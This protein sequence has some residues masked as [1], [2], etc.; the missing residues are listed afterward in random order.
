MKMECPH[1]CGARFSVM[2]NT[3]PRCRKPAGATDYLVQK[4]KG[5]WHRLWGGKNNVFKADCP[6][7]KTPFSLT[8]DT[9]PTCGT[10]VSAASLIAAYA[11][12]LVAALI[13][14]RG[15]ANRASPFEA[16]AIRFGCFLASAAT[17]C[18]LLA[19]AERKFVNGTNDWISPALATCIYVGLSLS[20]LTWF[21]PKNLGPL[22]AQLKLLIKLS[23]LSNYFSTVLTI[24]FITDHWKVRSWLLIGT[25]IL[26]ML[27]IWLASRFIVPA[28]ITAGAILS[29]QNPHHADPA[30]RGG[31]KQHLSGRF[32]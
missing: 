29:G 2:E 24:L 8:S 15:R 14:I 30:Y 31:K 22:L 28:W 26:S 6:S 7:C 5:L 9:C 16:W 23:L 32:S 25:L 27:G 11:S 20:T 18:L 10:D 4:T 1:G 21:L 13:K 17:L 3:C 12:P 19:A